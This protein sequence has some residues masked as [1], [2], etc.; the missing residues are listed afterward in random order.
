MLMKTSRLTVRTARIHGK[1]SA[2]RAVTGFAVVVAAICV[3][4]NSSGTGTDPALALWRVTSEV[5]DSSRTVRLEGDFPADDLIQLAYPLQVLIRDTGRSA[6]YVRFDLAAGAVGALVGVAPELTDGL[7]AVEAV[8]L[9]AQG[10]P[11]EEA[12]VLFV[13]PGRIDVLLPSDFPAGQAE[14]QLFVLEGDSIV[15]SNPFPFAVGRPKS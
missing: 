15:L 8:A 2:T 5:G 1:F 14:A 11:N 10:T 13:G 4:S 7:D 3:A 9:L 12:E 6:V